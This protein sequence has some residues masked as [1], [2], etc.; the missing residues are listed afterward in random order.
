MSFENYMSKKLSGCMIGWL[1]WTD[2]RIDT[3]LVQGL[4]TMHVHTSRKTMC[5]NEPNGEEYMI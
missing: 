3:T 5:E 1:S 2:D 4:L